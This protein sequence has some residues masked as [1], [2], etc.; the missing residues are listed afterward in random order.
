MTDFARVVREDLRLRILQSL[1]EAPGYEANLHVLSTHLGEIGHRTSLDQ[2]RVEIAW[3]EEQGFVATR[4]VSSIAVPRATE[5]GV[6][7]A[8]GRVR[9]PGIRRPDP[10]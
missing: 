4:W 2:L 10:E 5:R 7:V 3:L 9:A 1:H 8:R 6:E